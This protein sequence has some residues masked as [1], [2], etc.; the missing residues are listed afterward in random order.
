MR[1]HTLI[2]L[3]L[4]AVLTT[5]TPGLAKP[6]A[7]TAR[8]SALTGP[9]QLCWALGQYALRRGLDRNAG[10]SYLTALDASRQWDRRNTVDPRV[11]DLHE[12]VMEGVYTQPHLSPAALQQQT[13]R[14]CMQGMR[15]TAPP[16][17]PQPTMIPPAR[18]RY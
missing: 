16:Q 7:P 3:A 9:E 5:G 11:I 13:E 18:S 10:V 15:D 14:G 12:I 6:K 2:A 17:D 8:P 1:R 4:A